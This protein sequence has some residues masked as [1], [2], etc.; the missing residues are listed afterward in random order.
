MTASGRFLPVVTL[1]SDWPLLGESR[2]S[3]KEFICSVRPSL[4][5]RSRLGAAG[6]QRHLVELRASE[7]GHLR[8]YRVYGNLPFQCPITADI[9]DV[10]S[11]LSGGRDTISTNHPQNRKY[12]ATK[13]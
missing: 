13:W 7:N 3:S 10:S 5:D 8:T 6:R 2:H 4:N 12:K 9:A 1:L 11:P